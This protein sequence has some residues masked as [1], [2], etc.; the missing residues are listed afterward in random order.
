[1]RIRLLLLAAIISIQLHAQPY[2]PPMRNVNMWTS[3][4]RVITTIE[5]NGKDGI[6]FSED[7][8]KGFWLLNDYIFS[9]GTIEFDVRGRNLLQRSFV[10]I[11]FH[12]QNDTTYDAVYFRPFNFSNPDTARRSRA[13]QY[14]SLPGFYWDKLRKDFPRQYENK[15][16]PVPDGDDW[17]HAK[18][19]ISGKTIKVFVNNST[20]P[21]LEVEK[22]SATKSGQLAFWVDTGSNGSFANLVITPSK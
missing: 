18:L 15:V 6:S 13:V 10:G 5:E 4:G 22:L 14:I 12:Y 19:V 1:M 11:A 8:G 16:N 20:I 2:Q 21:S 9:E 7:Q 3:S 17:F